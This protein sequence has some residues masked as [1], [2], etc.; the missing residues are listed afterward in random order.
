MAA[1]PAIVEIASWTADC[2]AIRSVRTAVFVAETGFTEDEEFDDLDPISR[3]VLARTSDGV[4]VGTGRL[5]PS[6]KLGRIAVLRDHRGR[7]IG[8]LLV[9]RMLEISKGM[10]PTEQQQTVYLHALTTAVD[11]Y[12]GFGFAV[13]GATFDEAGVPHVRMTKKLSAEDARRE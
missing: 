11:F 3:H 7:G 5:E 13:E 12:R 6:G 1:K 4:A 9:R 8:T 2:D 10:G